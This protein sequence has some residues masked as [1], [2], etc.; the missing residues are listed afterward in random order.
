M[1]SLVREVKSS[2]GYLQQMLGFKAKEFPRELLN[3]AVSSLEIGQGF[4]LLFQ[5]RILESMRRVVVAV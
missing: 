3:I 1:L 2:R 5:K 4:I